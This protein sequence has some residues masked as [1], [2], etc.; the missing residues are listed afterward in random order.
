MAAAEAA[1]PPGSRA[2]RILSWRVVQFVGCW[3]RQAEELRELDWVLFDGCSDYH[4]FSPLSFPL[5]AFL[6]FFNNFSEP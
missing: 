1:P 2:S 3:I 5:T 4:F 6:P